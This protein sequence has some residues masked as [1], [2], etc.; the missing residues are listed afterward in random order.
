MGRLIA[1]LLGGA[2]LMPFS[3]GG[4]AA[5]TIPCG[6]PYTVVRGDSISNIARRAF[7]QDLFQE[8]YEANRDV[9]GNDINVI[10]LGAVLQIP[11]IG[12]ARPAAGQQPSQAGAP[13]SPVTGDTG[14]ETAGLPKPDSTRSTPAA[15]GNQVSI[16]LARI[17][18]ADFVL[19]EAII[20]PFLADIER[21]TAGRIR[22]S[23]RQEAVPDQRPPIERLGQSGIDGAIVFNG[24]LHQ[25]HPLLQITLSP[26]TGGSAA[27]TAVALWRT[28]KTHLEAGDEFGGVKLLGFVSAPPA[29]LWSDTPVSGDAQTALLQGD[30]WTVPVLDGGI[31][32]LPDSTDGP[33]VFS[34]A[35]GTARTTGSWTQTRAVVEVSG[36]IYVPTFSVVLDPSKWAEISEAD[37]LAIEALSGEALALRS[38]RWDTFDASQ[39][40]LMVAQGL[41][42]LEP[43][44]NL[45]A[46]LQDRARISWEQWISKA[47]ATGVGGFEAIEAFF[48]EMERAKRTIPGPGGS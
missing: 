14:A 19:N 48:A 32:D 42:V 17:G 47:D 45:L 18:P 27:Q 35:Y 12:N 29:H 10:V 15:T 38:A 24:A 37:R 7:G 3:V 1:V 28:Y 16:A 4:A 20:D 26:M 6:E 8:L 5:Q 43:D 33:E 34:M 39:K 44:I 46:E 36:G 11:C 22:F 13:A 21:V 31:T 2:L 41:T 25:S 9:I 40:S 23:A 30:V